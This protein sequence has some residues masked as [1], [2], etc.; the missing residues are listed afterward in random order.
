MG[1]EDAVKRSG[2]NE[3]LRYFVESTKRRL[4]T[5]PGVRD[6]GRVEQKALAAAMLG[7]GVLAYPTWFTETSWIGGMEAQ[8]AGLRI[9]T[10]PIAALN[11]TVFDRGSLIDGD[12]LSEEYQGAFIGAVVEALTEPEDGRRE[13]IRAHAREHFS[14]DGVVEQWLAL[15]EQLLDD[16]EF[17][18]MVPYQPV[19]K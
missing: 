15:F 19:T 5:L 11:E 4:R 3:V 17:G 13:E 10:S 12:W 7:A 16:A 1:L 9:V 18:M 6:M 14:W 8:A 2:G